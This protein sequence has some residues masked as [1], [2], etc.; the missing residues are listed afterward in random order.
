MKA[1]IDHQPYCAEQERLQE[2]RAPERVAG[3]GPELI[4]ELFG[5]E[6]PSLAIGGKEGGLAEL[7]NVG[8]RLRDAELQMVAGDA[9]VVAEG[10]QRI[11]RPVAEVLQIDE[12]DRRARAIEGCPPIIAVGRP[13]LDFRR[14][15]PDLERLGR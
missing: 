3:V 12:V 9:L 6:R 1:G 8:R 14:H 10:R 11:F 2:T 7:G 4:G 15:A 13:V 5:I